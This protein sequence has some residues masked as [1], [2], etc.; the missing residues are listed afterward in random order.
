MPRYMLDTNICIYLI[1]HQ[2]EGVARRFA[3]CRVGEV[4]ISAITYAELA[5]GVS[6]AENPEQER[7]ALVALIEDIPVMPFDTAAGTAYGPVWFA[8]RERK[9]GHLDKLI[10]AHAISLGVILITNSIYNSLV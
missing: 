7:A 1:K 3:Q 10:A 2:P 8:T 6:M 9:K 5:Y 4:V